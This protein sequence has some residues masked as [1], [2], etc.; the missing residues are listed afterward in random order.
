MMAH[1]Q[2][3]ASQC[4]L[5]MNPLTPLSLTSINSHARPSAEQ[6]EGLAK[7]TSTVWQK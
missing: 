7:K 2:W 6:E 5:S 3:W 1:L 4:T